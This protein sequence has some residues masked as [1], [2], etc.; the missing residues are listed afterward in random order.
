MKTQLSRNSFDPSKRYSGVYQQMG[1]MLTDA[2]WNE[3]AELGK[4]RLAQTITDVINKGTPRERGLVQVL[5]QADGSEKYSL[6]WGY[7]YVDGIIAEVRADKHADLDDP[8]ETKFEYLHQA[9]LPRA[10]ALPANDYRLYLDVWERTVIALEDQHI[11]D[12]GLHGADTCTRTQTMAQVKW[13]DLGIDPEN[14]EHNPPKGSALASLEIRQGSTEPDPCDP[15]AQEIALQDKLGNY[16][17]R[18]EVHD[19]EYGAG[20]QPQRVWLKWSSENGAEQF[21]LDSVPEGFAGANWEYEFFNGHADIDAVVAEQFATEKHLGRHFATGFSP[22]RGE[23]V[24]GYPDTEPSGFSAVRRWDGFCEL[25]KDGSIWR[26]VSG[27]DRGVGL[28]SATSSDAHGHVKEGDIVTI[29]HNT[30]T[31]NLIIADSA[32]LAGDYWLGEVR[33]ATHLAGDII[34]DNQAPIGIEHHY[35][36]LGTVIDD[37][38]EIYQG[39]QCKRFDFPSLTDIRAKD[40]CYDNSQCADMSSVDNVQQAIDHLC[41]ERDLK[42]HNKHLHGWGIVCGLV[43]NCGPNAYEDP[44]DE[45]EDPARREI[46]ITKGYA[47]TCEGDDLVWT[48]EHQQPIDLIGRI[49]S[50][51]EQGRAILDNGNGSV[52]LRLDKGPDGQPLLGIEAYNAAKHSNDSLLE[53]TLLM[54]FVQHCILDLVEAVTQELSFLDQDELDIEEGGSTGL[55]SQGRRKSISLINLLIQLINQENGAFVYLS[56]KEHGVLRDIYL[57]LRNLL[58]SKTFCAMYDDQEFPEYPSPLEGPSTFFGKNLHTKMVLH[59]SSKSLYTYGGTNNTI[60]VYDIDSQKLVQVI[61]MPSAEGAEVSAITF[62]T[63]GRLMMAA[64]S[65]R[66]IDSVF[67]IARVNDKHSWEQMTILCDIEISQMQISNKDPGLIYAV[68]LGK[69]LFFLR[70]DVMMEQNKP[71][72]DPAFAFNASGHL[73]IDQSSQTA[74]CTASNEQH[75]EA[76]KYDQVLVLPLDEQTDVQTTVLNLTDQQGNRVTGEDGIAL[77]PGQRGHVYVVIDS[78]GDEK[79]L[80]TINTPLNSQSQPSAQLAIENTQV[81]LSFHTKGQQLVLALEDGYRL[82]TVDASGQKTLNFRVPVQIQPLDL[83]VEQQSG[84]VYA[85]NYLSNTV[86]AI[87]PEHLS[88]SDAYLNTLSTYRTDILRAF[89]GLFGGLLQY[90]KDCFCDHLLVKCPECDEDSVIY[91][92]TVEIRDNE[93]YNICN[94]DK[95]KYVKSFPTMGYWFSIIP[96]WP[97]LKAALGKMC[98]SILPD[99]FNDRRDDFV[100]PV[101][102]KGNA[103]ATQKNRFSAYTTR[104]SMQTYQRTDLKAESRN[105]I[106]ST[107]FLGQVASDGV[108]GFANSAKS[109]NQGVRK[110]ALME[111][112]VNQAISELN[113][114]NIQV[115]GV[116]KYDSKDANKYLAEFTQ[117][118]QRIAPDSKVTLYQKNGKVA[119]YAV[120]K[121]QTFES[122]NIDE[123]T[124]IELQQFEA[125]KSQLSDFSSL[126]EELAVAETR[127][128]DL[129]EL[130]QVQSQLS[131]LK[132][133]KSAMQDELLILKS[134]VDSVK[135]ERD[136]LSADVTSLHA[137][138]EQAASKQKALIQEFENS[139]P[140]GDLASVDAAAESDLQKV[141][142]R[143]I[144]ELAALDSAKR[145][146]LT[147]IDTSKMTSL[148]NDAKLRIKP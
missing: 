121:V 140:I 87:P 124:K 67:G 59:P 90:L 93:I 122:V 120:E 128:A 9:D 148:I 85:L 109:K 113:N 28:S 5:P 104:S 7:V 74:Y 132:T 79:Q 131:A 106:K 52:C 61:E 6:H 147:R 129:A 84:H 68:G 86:S 36:T 34:L 47:I 20:G 17:F 101:T 125:R 82:Q 21:A 126:N 95:R 38:F 118:P 41:K 57:S 134:Q 145:S 37:E 70:P 105:Q 48:R 75:S 111:S 66:G 102:S 51:S 65:V 31:I 146:D 80:L 98:C 83:V 46:T 60:N 144:G 138:L 89:Y 71:Q 141:G 8:T 73:Q 100:K 96:V 45:N 103:P 114:N 56:R 11:K 23:L 88:S 35:M 18:V 1:R 13:C 127:R 4:D 117:T 123:N 107:K 27:Y 139:R 143:T 30:L 72:P 78:G 64:A 135:T 50:M 40:V 110:Q 94:F 16:L 53:G 77:Q 49:Q 42:W 54:D 14:P 22:S 32:L 76:L 116:K 97:M 43:V 142:V 62:S 3:L 39:D 112:D 92:A 63:D 2:D 99:L 119:F 81:S 133:Q 137:N 55:V 33:Q 115:A 44:D 108:L 15:C 130:A 24:N 19:V 12:A 26:L 136:S 10:P 25:A 58:Q 91:L 69:G 29:N